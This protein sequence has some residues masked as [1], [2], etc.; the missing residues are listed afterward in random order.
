MPP[1]H[2][3]DGLRAASR[4]AR[5]LPGTG[6]LVLSHYVAER[7]AL[8]LLGASAEGVGYLLKDR[9]AD[10]DEFVAAVRRVAEGGLG[11]RPAGRR[12]A[13]S[14][15]AADDPLDELSRAS[16]RCWR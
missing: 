6:V 11:A 7:Y 2:T 12:R 5:E 9:V 8:E 13:C 15:A 14:A 1:D 10:L 4:S 3:D 16:A